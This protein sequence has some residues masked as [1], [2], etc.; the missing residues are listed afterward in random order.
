MRI[1][2]IGTGISGLTAA[3]LLHRE[4][5]ITV[6]EAND[7]VGG[8]THTVDVE[9]NSERYA[10]DTG[11]IVFNDRTYPNLIRI[12]DRLGVDSLP[13]SMSFSVRC[14]R[15]DIE[16]NGS[17]LP[18]LFAQKRN[19]LRPRFYRMIRDI[20]RFNKESLAV[21]DGDSE[22]ATVADYLAKHGYSRE[23]A[24]LYLLP[25]GAAIWSCP[26]E[27]FGEFP[28]RF[29]VEFYHNHG[30]LSLKNRPQWYVVTGGSRTYVEKMIEP[31]RDRIHL[32][33]PVESVTRSDDEVVVRVA[34][35]EPQTYDHVVFACHSDQALRILGDAATPDERELL[36]EFPYQK[37]IAVL[38]TDSSVL[39][40]RRVAWAAWNYHVPQ[41]PT[42]RSATV[43]YNMNILQRLSSRHTFNVTLNSEDSIDDG[44]ILGR[45]EY[46]HPVFT[47][48]RRAAQQ[49][50]AELLNQVRSSF[51]GA[52]WG[53]GFHEDGVNS[54]LAVCRSLGVTPPWQNQE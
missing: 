25:M 28:I 31:F 22:D 48:R 53:N 54:A 1:A 27:T 16:Y 10:I 33:S 11:F 20:L 21:L 35:R 50:H 9:L 45:F 18:G 42:G 15:T 23:F 34:G 41:N 3:W 14:D 29:I 51:C 2:I 49:R 13:T 37:N 38:H 47:L 17:T 8:H 46:H 39:P 44:Q 6:Y 32:K 7:Y 12:F 24:D 52:Y 5:D 36:G 19:L 40:R 26:L 30:L 43:T 4:H